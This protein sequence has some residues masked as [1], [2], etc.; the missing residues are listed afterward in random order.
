LRI[1]FLLRQVLPYRGHFAEFREFLL[2]RFLSFFSPNAP[3]SAEN[4]RFRQFGAFG[5]AQQQ[6]KV[7]PHDAIG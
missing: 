3:G 5:N 2:E 1:E 7:V 6:M 4:F